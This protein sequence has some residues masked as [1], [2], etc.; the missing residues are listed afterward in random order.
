[1]HALGSVFIC[2][3]TDGLTDGRTDE[4]TD[5]RDRIQDDEKKNSDLELVNGQGVEELVSDVEAE[6]PRDVREF[7]VPVHV[8]AVLA[9]SARVVRRPGKKFAL[10]QRVKAERPYGHVSRDH[11]HMRGGFSPERGVSALRA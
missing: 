7:P 3:Q 1:M 9:A 10:T 4:L 8:R 2:L 11:R 6:L 5:K